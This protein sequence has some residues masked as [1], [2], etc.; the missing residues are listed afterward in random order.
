M[1]H[2]RLS[3][4][5]IL[6]AM[7]VLTPQGYS[8]TQSYSFDQC[9]DIVHDKYITI[10][11]DGNT[12]KTWHDQIVQVSHTPNKWCYFTH[13]HGSNPATIAPIAANKTLG[14]L[15]A[16]GYVASKAN[17]N[18]GHVGFKNYI[19]HDKQGY[20]VMIT[21]HFGTSNAALA[22]CVRYHSIDIVIVEIATQKIK[23]KLSAMVDF[24]KAV[25]NETLE[26]L[27][28]DLCPN[29]GTELPITTGSR[30]FP[31]HF[32]LNTGYEP[33]GTNVG[34]LAAIGLCFDKFI[35]NTYNPRTSCGVQ[36]NTAHQRHEPTGYPSNGTVRFITPNKGFEITGIIS[37]T[38]TT[39]PYGL[40]L[41]EPNA[42]NAVIQ[43]IEP[44]FSYK[45]PTGVAGTQYWPQSIYDYIYWEAPNAQ[46]P[47][48]IPHRHNP[49]IGTN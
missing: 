6:M 21:H 29:Q 48:T 49:L 1:K 45:F 41:V 14:I 10:G 9:S 16:F 33:W 46:A 15:P 5:C 36:C 39:D 18:E 37:G 44:G 25:N 3:I 23:T 22:A 28:P 13:E 11:P 12:Y 34:C 24:G 31:M 47:N 17:I 20:M 4:L 40:E 42:S 43:Y 8:Q 38:F 7:L 26:R 30:Q 2:L 35:F 27:T 19:L 32:S